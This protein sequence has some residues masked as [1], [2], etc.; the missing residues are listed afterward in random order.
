MISY[1]SYI[2]YEQYCNLEELNRML[3]NYFEKNIHSINLQMGEISEEIVTYC[4][5]NNIRIYVYTANALREIRYLRE[6]G[7]D[8]V[9]TDYPELIQ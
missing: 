8:G 3:H 4:N 7:V 2:L 5:D 9:F 1:L 6:I